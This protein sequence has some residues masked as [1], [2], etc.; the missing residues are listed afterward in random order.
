MRRRTGSITKRGPGA[1]R[2][3]LSITDRNG[4]R[5]WIGGEVKG[6]RADAERA[7][8]E[9]V[10]ERSGPDRTPKDMTLAKLV[11]ERYLPH[12]KS[13]VVGATGRTYSMRTRQRYEYSLRKH[14][15]PR[16]G[17]R[18]LNTITLE[19]LEWL[20]SELRSAGLTDPTVADLLAVTSAVF[21]FAVRHRLLRENP[22]EHLARP[23][24]RPRREVPVVDPEAVRAVLGLAEPTRFRLAAVLMLAHGLRREEALGLRWND[25]DLDRGE[26]H[27]RRALVGWDRPEGGSPSRP[28]WNLPK[29][30]RGERRVP[31]LPY[32]EAAFREEKLAQR[33]GRMRLGTS[34]AGAASPEDDQVVA[35]PD[36]RPWRPDSFSRAW[37]QFIDSCAEAVPRLTPRDLRAAWVSNAYATIADPKLL[38]EWGGHS[39]AVA[40]AHY[41][42]ALTEPSRVARDRLDQ[43]FGGRDSERLTK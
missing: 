17:N 7:L 36:G 23:S 39:E 16:L 12:L 6:S 2:V 18:K 33:R 27:V 5:G 31:L 21:T 1:Y 40:R 29:P 42:R 24:R 37:A 20:R 10:L 35:M 9:L 14:I 3:R 34:W 28:V 15:L 30:G 19:D 4:K 13:G 41:Q 32:F 25:V 43:V 11:E 38:E 22:C 26:I 8:A